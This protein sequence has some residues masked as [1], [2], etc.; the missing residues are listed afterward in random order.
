MRIKK[1]RL[2]NGYKRFHDLTIDLGD[3]P[4]RIIALVGPNG[5]GK[6]SV[7][8]GMLF[9]TNSHSQI[10]NT[11]NKDHNYHSMTGA[12]N[13]SHVNIEIE[14]EQKSYS[15]LYNERKP[16]GKENTIFSFRS[17]YRYNSALKVTQSQAMPE[18]RLNNYG[19]TSSADLDAKMENNYRRLYIKY[20]TYLNEQNCQPSQAKAHIID[21][22]NQSIK[23]CLDLELYSM[24]KIEAS[25]GTLY[26][27]KP[28]HP[29]EFEFN[30]LSSGEKE[31]IDIL[32]DLYLRKKEY[33]DTIFLL[34]EPELHIST[35]IQKKLLVE[36]NKLVGENCQVW[37]ST[38]SIGF[39]RA[40]QEEYGSQCQIINFKSD[41]NLASSVKVIKPSIM[42]ASKWREIFEIALDDLVSLVSPRNIIYCEGRDAP[43]NGGLERGLDANV[44]NKIFSEKHC[45]TLFVS[46]GGN[47]ELDQRSS[48]AIAIISKALPGVEIFILKDRDISSGKDTTEAD[49]QLYLKNNPAAHRVLHRWEIE[50]YLYDKS[51]LNKYCNS[52]GL[53]FNEAKYDA[54]VTDI[55]NQNL[56]D[57]TGIIK[58]IC[59]ITTSINAEIFKQNLSEYISEDMQVY[60]ELQNCIFNRA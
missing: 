47:T 7:L 19:A 10:G 22:L 11:G 57:Q 60:A 15:E 9:K 38:H 51:V 17:P 18:I 20:D 2:F 4:K 48:I 37:L 21:E 39:L 29:K 32:L 30:V 43:G 31:V 16:I 59:G 25:K 13:F 33:D 26:F 55:I 44:F 1:V 52:N 49:R 8:D 41:M 58:N 24:G 53:Q 34:D 50:N 40:I 56:K 54:F 5:C 28:D 6:S 35:A 27:K 23:N 12:P 46:S 3:S 14:F 36:I 45:D 42:S